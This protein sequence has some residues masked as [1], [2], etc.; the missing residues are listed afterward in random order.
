MG[1]IHKMKKIKLVQMNPE[2]VA[3]EIGNFIVKSVLDVPDFTGGIIGLSGGVDSTVTAALAKRAFDKYNLNSEKKLYLVGYLLP[4]STNS[5]ADAEDGKKVAE[6]LNIKYE[7]IN[8][9]PV[10]EAYKFT[11]PLTFESNRDKGNL[12]AEIRATILHQ[13]SATEK[14]LVLGTGN[15]DEDFC[16]GYYTLFGDGAVHISPIGNLSKRLVKQMAKYLGFENVANRAP[17]AGLELGQTDFRDLGY[18][19][20]TTE[21]VVNGFEQKLNIKE[22]LEDDSFIK[23]SSED[24]SE[25]SRIHKK[26]KF[27]N[28]KEIIL[29]IINRNKIAKAK[30]NIV[31]PPA[32]NITLNYDLG[33]N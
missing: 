18:K 24:L 17:T 19:Y 8:I 23:S 2:K 28:S 13:K 4:S 11:N 12:M 3:D 20:E 27:Q 6:E 22:I 26:N 5:P 30:A 16:V 29:N 1:C 25:Y 15:R 9:Q 7:L 31:H 21:L 10:V 14:K 32:P 33:E